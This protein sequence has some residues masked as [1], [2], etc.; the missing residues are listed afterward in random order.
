MTIPA[1]IL[2]VATAV[3]AGAGA[4]VMGVAIPVVTVAVTQAAIQAVVIAAFK[5]NKSSIKRSQN[6]SDLFA[7]QPYKAVKTQNL[8]LVSCDF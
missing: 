8:E 5:Q 4:A 7:Y 2:G 1:A 3:A 6:E